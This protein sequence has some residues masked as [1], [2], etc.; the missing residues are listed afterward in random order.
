MTQKQLKTK[1]SEPG[2]PISDPKSAN[3]TYQANLETPAPNQM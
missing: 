3:P 2:K 1:Q